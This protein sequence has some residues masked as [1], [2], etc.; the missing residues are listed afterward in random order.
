MLKDENTQIYYHLQTS[1]TK[2]KLLE[3]SLSSLAL[4]ANLLS[5]QQIF[6]CKT[7]ILPQLCQF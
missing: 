5:L 3:I 1:Q 4:A 7:Y 2:V 6:I